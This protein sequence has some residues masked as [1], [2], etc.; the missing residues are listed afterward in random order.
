MMK[1]AN[2]NQKK[3]FVVALRNLFSGKH[4]KT[5][6]VNESLNGEVLEKTRMFID[7]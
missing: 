5:L 1:L 7:E 4:L 2:I 3:I 6:Q